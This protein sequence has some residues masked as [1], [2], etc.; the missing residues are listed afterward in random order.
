MENVIH[1]LYCLSHK[2]A[3]EDRALDELALTAREVVHETRAQVVQHT[4]LGL[5]LEIFNDV[6][7]NETSTAGDKHFHITYISP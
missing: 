5:A 6:A 7:A 4:H 2:I 3:V 1:A